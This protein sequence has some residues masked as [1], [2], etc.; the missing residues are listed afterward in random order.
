MRKD[1]L[2]QAKVKLLIGDRTGKNVL[3]IIMFSTFTGL[4]CY[5]LLECNMLKWTKSL[6]TDLV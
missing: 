4:Q 3:W 1:L 5:I 6:W 2:K